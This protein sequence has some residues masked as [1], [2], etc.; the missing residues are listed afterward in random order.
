MQPDELKNPYLGSDSKSVSIS[1]KNATN[2]NF[3]D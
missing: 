1:W 2:Q 3:F